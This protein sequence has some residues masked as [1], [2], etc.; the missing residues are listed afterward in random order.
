MT[1]KNILIKR[2][3]IHSI[4]VNGPKE[5]YNTDDNNF[6]LKDY[7]LFKIGDKEAINKYSYKLSRLI[8]ENINPANLGDYVVSG[9]PR[10]YVKKPANYLLESICNQIKKETGFVLETLDLLQNGDDCINYSARTPS[11]RIKSLKTRSFNIDPLKVKNKH[12][13]FIDDM[14]NTG[15]TEK[16]TIENIS[17]YSPLSISCMYIAIVKNE[18]NSYPEF[19]D[20]AN[21]FAYINNQEILISAYK[22]DGYIVSGVLK[23][24]FQDK[25]LLKR[26]IFECS[27][28]RLRQFLDYAYFDGYHLQSN[29]IEGITLLENSLKFKQQ[30]KVK[31]EILM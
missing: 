20:Y 29:M 6:S 3:S 7:S 24:L 21:T 27:E 13:I 25:H 1:S 2:Q 23:R 11:E 12:F 16:F 28:L 4:Y 14:R 10:G 18:K 15:L 31:V 22:T 8:I 17:R 5:F 26:V 19:E 9:T 30:Q